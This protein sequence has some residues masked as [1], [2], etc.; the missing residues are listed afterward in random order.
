MFGGGKLWF[1]VRASDQIFFFG[2]TLF[3]LVKTYLKK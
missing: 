2:N 3:A 1:E